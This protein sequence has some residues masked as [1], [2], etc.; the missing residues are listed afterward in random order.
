MNNKFSK[1]TFEDVSK[2]LSFVTEE[3]KSEVELYL[4]AAKSYVRRYTGLTDEELDAQ[5]YF[6]MPVLMLTSSFYE[7]KSIEMDKDMSVVYNNLLNLGKVNF[8]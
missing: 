7:N 6:I 8:L 3:D 5:E 2:Y 4:L 1:I